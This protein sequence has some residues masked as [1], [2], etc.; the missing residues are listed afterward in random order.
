VAATRGGDEVDAARRRLERINHI[1][2]LML[3]NRSFDHTLGYLALPEHRGQRPVPVEGLQPGD[4]RFVLTHDGA[5]YEP[6]PLDEAALAQAK[7]DPPHGHGTVRKQINGGSMDGFVTAFAD[8]LRDKGIEPSQEALNTVMGYLTPERVPVFDHL[9]RY[10]CVCDHWFCSVPGPTMPN[11][12]FSVAGTTHGVM[13]NKDLLIG[14]F[15]GFESFFRHLDRNDWRWY[16]SDP[17]ILRAIDE[18]Y[19]FDND[20]DHFAYFNECTETQ[21]RSF[22]RDVLG[23]GE[24]PAALPSVSWIDPNFAMSHMLPAWAGEYFDGPGSNDDHPPAPVMLGQQLVNI[25]YEALA[26]SEYWDDCLFVVTYDEHGGFFDHCPPPNGFGPR[27]PALLVSPHVKPGVCSTVFDHASLIKTILLRF[28]GRDDIDDMPDRVAAAADLSVALRDEPGTVAYVPVPHPGQA[29][30]GPGDLTAKPLPPSGSTLGHTV[31]FSDEKLS[32][33]QK[34]LIYGIALPLRTG[35]RVYRRARY[36]KPLRIFKG[37]LRRI[38]R[39]KKR[40]EPRRP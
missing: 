25:I 17:G 33:L 6:N 8:S 5:T 36:W 24:H 29:A 1:V 35:F 7:L 22:L 34:D 21:P 13:D 27:V 23:D 11:R 32:D 20:T 2:V 9:A 28:G 4:P 14:N 40:L 30:V 3:E 26:G 15:G 19:M 18:L 38:K 16:S 31:A 39:P 12:F 10:F 37:L